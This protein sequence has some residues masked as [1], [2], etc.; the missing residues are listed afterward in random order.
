MSNMYCPNCKMNVYTVRE[1]IDIG[2]IIILFIFTAGIGILIY[3]A[4]Y[5]DKKVNRCIHCKSVCKPLLIEQAPEVNEQ[6]SSE[7]KQYKPIIKEDVK[8][9][10]QD[11][12]FCFNCGVKLDEREGR[13]FCPY[14]GT[15][16]Y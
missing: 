13:N 8:S 7:V 4:V 3:L 10:N 14:C 5:Y 2:L 16:I 11:S 12:K 1:D 6:A 15:N 9:D